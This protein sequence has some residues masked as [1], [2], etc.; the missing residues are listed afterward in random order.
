M[1][2]IGTLLRETREA[3]GLTIDEVSRRTH[4]NPKYLQALESSNYQ[5]LPTPV[6]VRGFLRNY[7]S[8]LGLDAKSLGQQYEASQSPY[9]TSFIASE[10]LKG[11]KAL[12]EQE[13]SV[14][15]TSTDLEINA[16]KKQVNTD[17]YVRAIIIIALL[18]AIALVGLRFF[19][20]GKQVESGKQIVSDMVG[21]IFQGEPTP[22]PT[23]DPEKLLEGA[24]K[25]TEDVKLLE[26]SRNQADPSG[27]PSQIVPEEVKLPTLDGAEQFDLLL[28]IVDRVFLIVEVDGKVAF[29]GQS[30]KGEK[31][32]FTAYKSLRLTAGNAMGLSATINDVYIGRL[33]ARNQPF[34]HTWEIT[35]S[36][37]PPTPPIPTTSK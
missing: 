20:G 25:T 5:A 7:A 21:L 31:L 30:K 32:E 36:A 34:E 27:T 8:L 37:T 3:K 2:E 17:A 11:Q 24:E 18:V 15:F 33:G 28:E 23:I 26:T 10:K 1:D 16:S 14:F 4:I 13:D 19:Q 12:S 35:V 22:M 9:P 29:Q 6:H